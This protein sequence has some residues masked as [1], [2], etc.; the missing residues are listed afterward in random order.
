MK[1][2]E[3]SSAFYHDAVRPILDARFPSLGHS[4]G[5]LGAGSDV[6]G[7][8][9]ETS[10]DH[11]WGPQLTLF[12]DP[13]AFDRDQVNVRMALGEE[14]RALP[15]HIGAVWQF[16]D[17]TDI[18]SRSERCGRLAALATNHPTT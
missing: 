3:L 8:D 2:L 14:V 1:G 13:D 10:Q 17:S 4:A 7:F 16:A 6:L 12:L 5:R 18:L 9:D 11:G 15:R